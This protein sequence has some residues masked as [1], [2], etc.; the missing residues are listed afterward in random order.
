MGKVTVIVAVIVFY[1]RLFYGLKVRT[2]QSRRSLGRLLGPE[3]VQTVVS[4]R[5]T[6]PAL[7]TITGRKLR[8]QSQTKQTDK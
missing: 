5:H 1:S 3:V 7:Q 2:F 6:A 8:K 4:Q